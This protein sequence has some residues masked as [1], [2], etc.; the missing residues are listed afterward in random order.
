MNR[1]SFVAQHGA[2]DGGSFGLIAWK[3]GGALQ[4]RYLG[5]EPPEGLGHLQAKLTANLVGVLA[6]R[7]RSANAE[8][9][10]LK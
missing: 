7:L 10:G 1:H 5:A 4:H 3:D 2:G 6:S 9:R 8:I